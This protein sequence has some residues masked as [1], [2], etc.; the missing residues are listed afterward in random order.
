MWSLRGLGWVVVFAGALGCGGKESKTDGAGGSGG[1]G[2]QGTG[3]GAGMSAAGTSS[4]GTGGSATGGGA[5]SAGASSAGKGGAGGGAGSGSAGML[6]GVDLDPQPEC[7]SPGLACN[8][9][10]LEPGASAN[11]CTFLTEA[12]TVASMTASDGDLYFAGSFP[13]DIV[14]GDFPP[15]GVH[16]IDGDTLEKTALDTDGTYQASRIVVS[17]DTVYYLLSGVTASAGK[18]GA[19]PKTGG[20]ATELVGDLD[21]A[22]ELFV[23]GERAYVAASFK[24]STE[25]EHLFWVPL[26]GG[27]PQATDLTG[28]NWARANATMLVA[29]FNGN[30]DT[31]PLPDGTPAQEVMGNFELPLNAYWIDDEYVYWNND[32]TIKRSPL[33]QVGAT[34]EQ[35][36]IVQELPAGMTIITDIGQELILKASATDATGLYVMPASGGTPELVATVGSIAS[37][38][39][40]D[41]DYV[42]FQS[43]FGV[44]RVER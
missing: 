38:A 17:G 27:E 19:V 4:S 34:E 5:G 22:N 31:A 1:S 44:L 11:G 10:C 40:L 35:G 25:L 18:L 12:Q 6:A 20:T 43:G 9:A 33:S 13:F 24:S 3:G 7:D 26:A 42:Y 39:T 8:G 37:V 21:F 16:R 41:A 15:S 28:A 32:G 2:G 30:I 36:E 14:A 23:I 29:S